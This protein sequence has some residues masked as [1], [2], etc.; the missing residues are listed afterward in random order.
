[1]KLWN[2]ASNLPKSGSYGT[3][4][5]TK[6]TAEICKKQTLLRFDRRKIH[7][8]SLKM[9]EFLCQKVNFWCS[10]AHFL[11]HNLTL[12]SALQSNRIFVF[13]SRIFKGQRHQKVSHFARNCPQMWTLA[14][15]RQNI[16]PERKVIISNSRFYLCN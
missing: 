3:L 2:L 1:M 14:D 10:F 8:L 12:L 6:I 7:R 9:N 13:L 15:K 16:F 4:K 5:S 11:P